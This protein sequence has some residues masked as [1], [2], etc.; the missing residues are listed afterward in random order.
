MQEDIEAVVPEAMES[1]P[2][3]AD[4]VTA[5]AMEKLREKMANRKEQEF[6]PEDSDVWAGDPGSHRR[7]GSTPHPRYVRP[8]CSTTEQTGNGNG[9]FTGYKHTEV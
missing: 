3:T 7:S 8:S 2:E 1:T 4:E 6:V 9:L 5:D